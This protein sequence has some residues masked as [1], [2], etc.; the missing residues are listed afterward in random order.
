MVPAMVYD[1]D[2]RT[3][4]AWLVGIAA[5]GPSVKPA[6]VPD[7]PGPIAQSQKSRRVDA[8]GR[9]VVVGEMCPEGAGGRP[10]VAPLIMRGV[11]WNDN[12]AEVA[13][14]VERGTVPRFFIYGVDGKVAGTFDTLGIAEV[15]IGQS[16]ATGTYVGASPCT[17]G[18][19]PR[20][21]EQPRAEDPACRPVT[22]GCGIAV[23]DITT[24]EETPAKAA[25]AT[26]G[27]CVSGNDLAVD[28]DGDGKI[29]S[30]PIAAV[31]DGIRAPAAE[32]PASPTATASCRPTFQ[33]YNLKIAPPPHA[34]KKDADK[35]LVTVDVLAVI[36][37]DGDGRKELVLGMRFPTTRSIVVY[38]ASSTP[39][40]LELA[41]EGTSIMR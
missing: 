20:P 28:I 24:T 9:R 13:T 1:R 39:E 12:P 5:C 38:T 15:G 27:V 22:K 33:V 4:V 25:F 8:T 37:L 2:R 19:T 32:W 11:T 18:V 3:R 34:N 17:Y 31:L 35:G 16:V 23:G 36:D 40:R 7:Q 21:G 30:F 6:S 10:A 41:G 26:G 14:A 29:E